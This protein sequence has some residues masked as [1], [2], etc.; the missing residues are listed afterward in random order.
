MDPPELR[1]LFDLDL[2][3]RSGSDDRRGRLPLPYTGARVVR[4]D[5]GIAGLAE[6]ARKK[7]LGS[8]LP[9]DLDLK[10][11]H[12]PTGKPLFEH[13]PALGDINQN[14]LG[15][16]WFLAALAAIVHAG[17][18]YAIELMMREVG[19]AWD[20]GAFAYVRLWDAA[21]QPLY[22]EV[23]TSLLEVEGGVTFHSTGGLWAPVLEK[24]MTALDEQGSLAPEDAS[25]VRLWGS[26]ATRA[27]RALLGVAAESRA[28]PAG[29]LS[30]KS[31][32]AIDRINPGKD[33]ELLYR[34]LQGA[35]VPPYVPVDVFAGL[36]ELGSAPLFYTSA[37]KPWATTTGLG[38]AWFQSFVGR[39]FQGSVYRQEEF[40]RFLRAFAG[41]GV[42]STQWHPPPV[43]QGQPPTAL[44]A[45]ECVCQWARRT[46]L[47]PGKRGSG[48]Y[49]AEQAR[50]HAEIEQH[51]QAHRPVCLASRKEVGRTKDAEPGASGEPMSKGLAGGH[52]YAVTGCHTDPNTGLRFV[53]VW[54]PWGRTGRG[55][56]FTFT[57]SSL[58]QLPTG[59]AL[60]KALGR[61]IT[62]E[63]APTAY[64]TESPLFWLELDDVTK[65]F[66][67]LYTCGSSTP[68]LILEARKLAGLKS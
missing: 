2:W 67:D 55:Y 22:V 29:I 15:D 60:K 62:G 7:G 52:V 11:R 19:E 27:F 16:C 54:N 36:I 45:A 5:P 20:A 40:E 53:Q 44:Q 18:G 49:T 4:V 51:L 63:R 17:T 33:L 3:P 61:K 50:L 42:N 34:V 56:T 35:D 9:A 38:A 68:G 21:L 47:F 1:D 8:R 13:L 43:T 6:R 46:L 31:D 10:P 37:W 12:V 65:R 23:D 66:H 32:V 58:R 59:A 41:P 28:I 64:E 24:A 14:Q 30:A 39:A 26:P 25:Y 57:D 48:F